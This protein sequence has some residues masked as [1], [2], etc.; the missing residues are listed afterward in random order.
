MKSLGAIA[1][2]VLGLAGGSHLLTRLDTMQAEARALA[3]QQRL[4][5]KRLELARVVFGSCACDPDPR[6]DVLARRVTALRGAL[7]ALVRLG[8]VAMPNDPGSAY[9]AWR[10]ED[11]P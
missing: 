10:A 6:V 7:L 4:D 5:E 9:V 3:A 11:P 1:L 8:K 2:L